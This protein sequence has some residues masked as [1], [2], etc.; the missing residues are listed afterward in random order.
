MSEI[1]GTKE[2]IFDVFVEMTS[3]SGYENVSMRDIARKVGIKGASIYNHFESKRKILEYAYDYYTEHMYDTRKPIDVMKKL[4]E[5]AS[6]EEIV[7]AL[8]FTFESSD[9]KKYMRMILI[10]KIVYMRLFHDPIAYAVFTDTDKDNTE[11]VISILKHGVGIGKID[12][13]FDIEIF[14]DVLVGAK[15]VMGIKAFADSAYVAGQLEREPRILSLFTRLLS[16]A[17]LN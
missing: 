2:L 6:A 13:G 3:V 11:Y 12:T 9:T 10:T 5:T 7:N 17:F 4:V 14:A 16:Y 8:A 1:S 15:T